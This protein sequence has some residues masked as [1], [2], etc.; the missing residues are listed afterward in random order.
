MKTQEQI[1]Q[2]IS[3]YLTKTSIH[4]FIKPKVTFK[5][6]KAGPLESEYNYNDFTYFKVIVKEDQ[7]FHLERIGKDYKI[8]KINLEGSLSNN[9]KCLIKNLLFQH[10]KMKSV[11][12]N[13]YHIGEISKIIEG[14]K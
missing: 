5:A 12:S 9:S 3:S 1:K 13:K 8:S 2:E 11:K 6:T 10:K 14:I 4:T 7:F